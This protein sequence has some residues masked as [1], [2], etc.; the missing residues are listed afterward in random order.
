[1]PFV[2]SVQTL[3]AEDRETCLTR[4]NASVKRKRNKTAACSEVV[5]HVGGDLN[6][7]FAGDVYVRLRRHLDQCPNCDVYIDSL[8]KVALLYRRY[9][10]PRL[11]HKLRKRLH[12]IVSLIQ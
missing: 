8:K 2:S 1:M 10:D 4:A 6:E 5:R 7:L 12:R 3:D 11:K 9:P